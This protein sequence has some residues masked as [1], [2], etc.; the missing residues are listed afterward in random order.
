[1]DQQGQLEDSGQLLSH[2]NQALLLAPS[3]SSHPPM[4]QTSG[5]G[6]GGGG[7]Q[8]AM[9]NSSYEQQ[10]THTHH[11]KREMEMR[12]RLR[13]FWE[14]QIQEIKK[15]ID[16]KNHSL[17]L[18]RIKK[19]MKSDEDVKMISAEAPMIFAKACEMFILE[20]TLRSWGNTEENKRRTL[21]RNDVALAVARTDIFDFLVDMIP[22]DH[23][24]NNIRDHEQQ[25]L[26][27]SMPPRNTIIMPPAAV[28]ATTD[29]PQA[30]YNLPH[31]TST[32]PPEDAIIN[33]R[34]VDPANIVRQHTPYIAPIFWYPQQQEQ[35]QEQEQEQHQFP[36]SASDSRS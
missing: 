15:I 25:P 23:E 35:E 3:S 32:N 33:S 20:L 4:V 34:M 19:I 18:A 2:A 16:F 24:N 36:S 8:F 31:P 9:L 27:F 30:Y 7:S 26:F 12:Q 11:H 5:G 28:V 13:T 17:P 14:N 29:N 1:M 6:G 22:R 10:Q 21:L